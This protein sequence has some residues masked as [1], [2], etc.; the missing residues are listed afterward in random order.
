MA[1]MP[2]NVR[3]R[4]G[5]VA[6]I[7][8]VLGMD[9]A[10]LQRAFAL[11][12]ELSRYQRFL[13]G[14]P[15]LTDLQAAYFTA[16]DHF[17]HEAFV[18]LPEEQGTDIVGVARFV[19]YRAEPTDADLAITVADEWQGRGLATVLLRVLSTRARMV[20][21]RRFKA[22]MLTDNAAVL[23]LLRRAGLAEEV[24]ADDVTTGFVEL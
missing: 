19:R 2:Q 4:T 8:P 17:H 10:E 22:D 3:L 18:A 6:W 21:I 1:P 15:H 20:G 24:V 11:L 23:A 13:T 5:H 16:V 7:R 9:A 14:T 12:S